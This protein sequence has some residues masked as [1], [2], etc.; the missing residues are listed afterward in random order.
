MNATNIVCIVPVAV[1][2]H[3]NSPWN[4]GVFL[5]IGAALMRDGA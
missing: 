1:Y 2:A 5:N 3:W 4:K